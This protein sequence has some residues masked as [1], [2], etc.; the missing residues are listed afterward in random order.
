MRRF[1]IVWQKFPL[2][3]TRSSTLIVEADSKLVAVITAI[4]ELRTEGCAVSSSVLGLTPEQREIVREYAPPI[5]NPDGKITQ[6]DEI[7]IPEFGKV[8][9]G[10]KEKEDPADHN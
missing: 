1:Q 3:H 6:V 2:G 5:G 8:I 7:K 4:V 10:K 9:S